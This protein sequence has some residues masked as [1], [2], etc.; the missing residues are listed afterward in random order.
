MSKAR[1]YLFD[2][3]ILVIFGVVHFYT[4]SIRKGLTHYMP[5]R[6]MTLSDGI[7]ETSRAGIKLFLGNLRDEVLVVFLGI[8]IIS[9]IFAFFGQRSKLVRYGIVGIC[10]ISLLLHFSILLT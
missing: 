4:W 9:G 8:L 10:L 5:I 1:R 2:L 3:V 7:S 6:E